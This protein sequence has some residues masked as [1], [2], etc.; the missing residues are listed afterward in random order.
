MADVLDNRRLELL[1]Q[2]LL[3]DAAFVFVEA[4]ASFAPRSKALYLGKVSITCTR[5][6]ELVV[7]IEAELA[8]S[9]AANLLG[10]EEDSEEASKS[11]ADA[12]GELVNILAGSVALECEGPCSIGIP[13]VTATP[14]AT[15]NATLDRALRRVN[16]VTENDQH[17][18]V[19]LASLGTA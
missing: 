14:G 11:R 16:L 15:A 4:S 1:S 9:L 13:A 8:Q 12:V 7:V 18:A 19:A 2:T 3:A 10:I 17:L 6:F 5:A